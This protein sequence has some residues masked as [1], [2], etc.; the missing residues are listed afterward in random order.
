MNPSRLAGRV[1]AAVVALGLTVGLLGSPASAKSGPPPARR[2]LVFSVPGF[3]WTEADSMRL[4]AFDRLFRNSAVADL[5]PRSVFASARRGDAYLTVSAGTRATADP[6]NDGQQL[7]RDER[8][9]GSAAGEVFARRSGHASDRPF[10]SV[11]WPTLQRLNAA[12]PY[13]AELGLLADTLQDAGI[14][15]HAV[16]NA[17]G[18]EIPGAATER[19]A[20]LAMARGD[21]SISGDL[22]PRLLDED[23]TQAFGVRTDIDATADAFARLWGDKGTDARA[24]V[25]VEASDL[26][27]TI[28]YRDLVDAAR[29]EELRHEALQDADRLLA[30]LLAHVDPERDAVLVVSPYQ[31]RGPASLLVTALRRPGSSSG[32]LKSASTQRKGIVTLVDVAPS[33]L[34]TMGVRRPVAMEGRPFEVVQSRA[35]LDAR[36]NHL[37][38]VNESSRFRERL[39]FPTTL[40]LVLVLGFVAGMTT[41]AVA[42]GGL[43]RWRPAI[44]FAALADL[45]VLP[46]SYLARAFPLQDL[47]S[48]FYWAFIVTGALVVAALA[49]QLAR[50]KRQ[51]DLALAS[52]AA[53]VLVVPL[54]DAVTGSHLH[55]GSAFGYSPTGNSRL[56]GISNYSFAQVAAAGLVLAAL[57]AARG[58]RRHRVAAVAILGVVLVVLGVPTWGSDVG[59]VLAMVPTIGVFAALLFGWRVRLR[60]IALAGLATLVVVGGFG[61]LDLARPAGERAHLGRLFERIGA[62]GIQPL[63]STIQRKL[64]ANARVSTSSFWVAAIPVGGLFLGFLRWWSPPP[65]A[66]ITR[67]IPPLRAALGA[68]LTVA[69]LGSLVNDSG[70]IVGGVIFLVLAASVAALAVELPPQ[71]ASSG[72]SRSA[73]AATP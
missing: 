3:A 61:L 47:G 54:L 28:R 13:D 32:Y 4:P 38:T 72:S 57:V 66:A 8:L 65:L 18:S 43:T 6:L 17:D 58:E 20:G 2:L 48:V 56:Y 10:L 49:R 25:L 24:V 14:G 44:A 51:P 55:L 31:A 45:A 21:G 71:E 16:G 12:Q 36:R 26:A 69:V 19:A 34:D 30:R 70:A 73:P 50:W 5:A 63:L 37:V 67:R 15:A 22:S 52:V 42:G 11:G 1:G 41:A 23:P 35:S 40:V 60:I 64:A 7:G 9:A 68:G 53:L 33:I 29:F 59:G 39:L 46:L 62:E 27:R